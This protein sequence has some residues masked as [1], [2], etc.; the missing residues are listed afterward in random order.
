MLC[1]LRHSRLLYI[2][3]LWLIAT[4]GC[5]Q[6]ERRI[7]ELQPDP[8]EI[9]CDFGS[10]LSGLEIRHSFVIPGS[11]DRAVEIREVRISC[12]FCTAAVAGE[13]AIPAGGFTTVEVTVDTSGLRGQFEKIVQLI[14][15]DPQRPSIVLVLRGTA[16]PVLECRPERILFDKVASGQPAEA[17]VRIEPGR[18]PIDHLTPSEDLLPELRILDDFHVLRT[19]TSESWLHVDEI[20]K[21]EDQGSIEYDI[22][23][24]LLPEA[25]VGSFREI[26]VVYTDIEI[27]P[28]VSIPIV[29]EVVP[30]LSVSPAVLAF[31]PVKRGKTKTKTVTV[32]QL[33]ETQLRILSVTSND[34]RIST[35]QEVVREG[36][37]YNLLVTLKS[38]GNKGRFEALLTIQTDSLTQPELTARVFGYIAE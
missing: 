29:G 9:I 12:D 37:E 34:P 1:D 24:M 16:V 21:I 6:L 18:W 15:D 38:E 32:K 5:T 27:K 26:M 4:S 8:E 13:R 22:A 11:P 36:K 28:K 31:G 3:W 30:A 33:G 2:M 17:T 19:E 35:H 10:I 25:P 20:Q 7:I 23:V 14:T